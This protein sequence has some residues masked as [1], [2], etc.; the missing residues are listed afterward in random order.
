MPSDQGCSDVRYLSVAPISDQISSKAREMIVEKDGYK[1]VASPIKMSRTKASTR[2][3]P[4]DFGADTD[5]VLK[6][7]GYT[8]ADI[9]RLKQSGAIVTAMRS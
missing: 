1:G 7:A 6:A 4:P 2:M 9:A 5:A 8:D 3:T